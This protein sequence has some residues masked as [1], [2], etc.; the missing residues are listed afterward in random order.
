MKFPFIAEI[1]EKK[2]EKSDAVVR[3]LGSKY[4]PF[5]VTFLPSSDTTSS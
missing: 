1:I 4:I 2:P 3:R 5:L